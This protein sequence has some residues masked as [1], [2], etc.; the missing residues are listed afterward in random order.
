MTSFARL[1]HLTLIVCL[2]GLVH[3]ASGF[4]GGTTRYVKKSGNDTA[5]CTAADPCLTIN[6]AVSIAD[7]GDTIQL[8]PGQYFEGSGVQIDK[9]LTIEGGWFL[10]TRVNI[11]NFGTFTNAF[12]V[13]PGAAVILRGM[14]ISGAGSSGVFN[15]GK[16]TLEKV[17]IRGN[18]D[19][20]VNNA[21]GAFL[22]MHN[23][24]IDDN[25]GAAGL[26]NDGTALISDSRIVG[27][28]RLGSLPG[29]GIQNTGILF[30]DRG[31]I[32]GNDGAGL[33]QF[34]RPSFDCPAGTLLQ[35]VTISGNA[36]RGVDLACG[37]MRLRHV[38]IAANT[39]DAGAG[40]LQIRSAPIRIENSILATNEG[41]QC[42]ILE[43]STTMAV[44]HSLIGD[45]S[46]PFFPSPGNLVGVDPILKALAPR[47][48]E[49]VFNKLF[50]I[51]A[52]RAHALKANSPAIDAGADEF[53]VDSFGDSLFTDQF[54]VPRPIDGNDDGVARCD[55]GA[56]EYKKSV[57]RT[58]R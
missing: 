12:T 7:P 40:G 20:G 31:L 10:G 19:R 52:T 47:A 51:G 42:G 27:T 58:D 16:L 24:G 11:S 45:F 57:V 26:S 25:K 5:P 37:E 6:H 13:D 39:A 54:G 23:V 21:L 15:R 48:G 8:G 36:N 33:A 1:L 55:M 18:G 29:D 28:G 38:T 35:N 56:F 4:A 46:C 34:T 14:T 44:S 43:N 49:T 32:A 17:W 9:D 22:T 3:D 53:C 41:A 2:L 30:M 50:H